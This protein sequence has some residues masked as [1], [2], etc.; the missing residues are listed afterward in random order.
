ML[1][2]CNAP[3]G[4]WCWL[5]LAEELGAERGEGRR[6]GLF[7]RWELLMCTGG[8]GRC[9]VLKL[10][11]TLAPH[12]S[13]PCAVFCSTPNMPHSCWQSVCGHSQAVKLAEA[14]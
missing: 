12:G 3:H 10:C 9:A 7:R 13:A 4:V 11:A 2:L 8:C 1:G 14:T 6:K 5:L